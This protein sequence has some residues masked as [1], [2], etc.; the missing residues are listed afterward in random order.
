LRQ[1][2]NP[3]HL[4]TVFRKNPPRTT[5]SQEHFILN[6]DQNQ[7]HQEVNQKL[8]EDVE[9]RLMNEAIDEVLHQ[10]NASCL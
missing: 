10:T 7:Q 6:I 1:S 9:L 4:T 3:N 2:R 8:K 5:K